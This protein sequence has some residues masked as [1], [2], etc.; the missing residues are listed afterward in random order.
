MGPRSDNRGYGSCS[1]AGFLQGFKHAAARGSS[2]RQGNRS[3]ARGV[4]A[5]TRWAA[6]ASGTREV[7]DWGNTIKPQLSK[8]VALREQRKLISTTMPLGGPKSKQNQEGLAGSACSGVNNPR[9]KW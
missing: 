3:N 2:E 4:T 5:V 7:V 8:N 9:P 6:I 1:R